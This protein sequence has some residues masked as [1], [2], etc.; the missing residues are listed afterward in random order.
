MAVV[1]PA[2]APSLVDAEEAAAALI[3]SG[4]AEVLLFGSVSRGTA[5]DDSDIDL[6]AIFADLDY[7]VR[8][9]RRR[10]LESVAAAAAARPVQV[11]VTDRPE[12]R[13]RIERVPSS[14]ER[15]IAAEVVPLA[16][17]ASESAADWDKEMVLPM[18]DPHEALAQ[19]RTWVLP[20]LEALANDTRRSVTEEDSHATPEDQETA[21]LN[22]LVRVCAAAAMTVETSLK[23]LAVLYA[24]KS[25]TK[26]DLK[27]NGHKIRRSLARLE[28]DVPEP[29]RSA[30]REVF[31]R[32]GVDIDVLSSWREEGT[33]P[34]DAAQVWDK[35]DR[36]AVAYAVMAPDVAAVLAEHLQHN[37]APGDPRLAAAAAS[38]D[39]LAA[40]I[41]AQ[42]VR[43]GVPAD[44]G[45]DG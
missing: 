13:A 39:R 16:A 26:Q 21:R 7:A 8:D 45:L 44:H 42:D 40:L 30:V 18:S 20:A 12:W 32:H 37:I 5:T 41:A 22:R 14:F 2:G 9:A 1:A 6:V 17:A 24:E 27:R 23:A 10:E 15:R 35:A 3:E 4:V 33:Y 36:L 31:D 11:H 25:P 34:D 43:A 28:R 38:R 29:A 19:F